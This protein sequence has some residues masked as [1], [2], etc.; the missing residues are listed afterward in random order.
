MRKK[1]SAL[2]GLSNNGSAI[3][4]NVPT[5]Y[6]PTQDQIIPIN[7]STFYRSKTCNMLVAI[8][9]ICT[10]CQ[11]EQGRLLKA[12]KRKTAM[13]SIPAKAKAPISQTSVKILQLT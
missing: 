5:I 7:Q 13:Q 2:K 4:H 12:E 11:K 9:E 8:N 1:W 6:D 3:L 10:N